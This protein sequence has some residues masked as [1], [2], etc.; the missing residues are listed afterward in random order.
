MNGLFG[1]ILMVF[2]IISAV[3]P[4]SAWYISIGWK[5]K[6]AEPS[7]AAL[8]MH[9]ITGVIGVVIGI[10]LIVSSCSSSFVSTKWEKQFQERVEAGEVTSIS[11]EY[12][13]RTISAEE[14]DKLVGMIKEATLTRFDLGSSYGYSG[15]GEIIF[16]DGEKVELILFGPSG[17]IELHPGEVSHAY[18]IN[19]GELESWIRAN[20]TNW[21]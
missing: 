15:A 19:S 9:R 2:G 14:Q 18:R 7:D 21:E 17:G 4:Q 16:R 6:D 11:F 8:A 3:S 12:G 10:I 1:L 5:F 13:Q 20:I